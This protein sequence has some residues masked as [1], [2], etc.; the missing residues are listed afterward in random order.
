MVDVLVTPL[1]NLIVAIESDDIKLKSS[2]ELKNNS[3]DV[4]SKC[5]LP[6]V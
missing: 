1:L 2:E 4:L 3:P 5:K 6:D